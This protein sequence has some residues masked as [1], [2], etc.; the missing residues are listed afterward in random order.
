MVLYQSSAKQSHMPGVGTRWHRS[1]QTR[2][3][4]RW[5][6]FIKI[7]LF[8]PGNSSYRRV[9]LEQRKVPP[10]PR[11]RRR[12]A[13]HHA[14]CREPLSKNVAGRGGGRRGGGLCPGEEEG[15]LLT[16]LFP[17]LGR[18][19]HAVAPLPASF[20]PVPA[21]SPWGL[22]WKDIL[23]CLCNA[24]LEGQLFSLAKRSHAGHTPPE[25]GAERSQLRL[26]S[27]GRENHT[28]G[29]DYTREL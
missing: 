3:L 10:D 21:T 20:P 16:S 5:G 26:I 2:C 4:Q 17:S 22:G 27:F 6:A 23:S 1:H 12:E 7:T 28:I 24:G 18:G 29:A 14:L 19:C 13:T 25:R 8:T 15:A 9:V 11:R